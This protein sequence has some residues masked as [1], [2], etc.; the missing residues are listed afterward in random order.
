MRSGR[1][2]VKAG[3]STDN[4]IA[5]GYAQAKPRHSPEEVCFDFF[6]FVRETQ[7]HARS[8]EVLEP[9]ISNL[10]LHLR[11]MRMDAPRYN[12]YVKGTLKASVTSVEELLA[13]KI[14]CFLSGAAFLLKRP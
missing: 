5:P 7:D 9:E 4:R 12:I 3:G 6:L 14:L 10:I 11:Q 1:L 8:L 13:K 2:Y